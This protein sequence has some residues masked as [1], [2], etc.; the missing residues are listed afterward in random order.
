MPVYGALLLVIYKKTGE[1]RITINYKL[2]NF[3]TDLD[4]FLLPETNDLFSQLCKVRL[5]S[6]IDLTNPYHSVYI[7]KQ[8]HPKTTFNTPKDFY[9]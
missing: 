7:L 1:L 2:I 4:R 8:D 9:E 6:R 3:N 5:F